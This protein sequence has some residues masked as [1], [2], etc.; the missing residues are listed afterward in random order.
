MADQL[1]QKPGSGTSMR[2]IRNRAFELVFAAA[3]LVLGVWFLLHWREIH[4]VIHREFG[5]SS[6]QLCARLLKIR[7]GIFIFSIVM[8]VV[9]LVKRKWW[10]CLGLLVLWALTHVLITRLMFAIPWNN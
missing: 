3:Y 8:L 9:S 2:G 10:L 5:P 4:A 7:D 6:V 1:E